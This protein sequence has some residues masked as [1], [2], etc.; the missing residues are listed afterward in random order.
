M[1]RHEAESNR[2]TAVPYRT[3]PYHIVPYH[4]QSTG[5][6]RSSRVRGQHR[7]PTD[8]QELPTLVAERRGHSGSLPTGWVLDNHSK[9]GGRGVRLGQG[10]TEPACFARVIRDRGPA[11]RSV[12]LQFGNVMLFNFLCLILKR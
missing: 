5:V 1:T 2:R 7:E 9:N 3:M 4:P 10:Q 8:E 6:S 11:G 12:G